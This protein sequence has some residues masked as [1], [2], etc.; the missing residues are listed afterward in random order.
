M[1]TNFTFDPKKHVY[2]LDGK[3]LTG[4]TTILG[5]IAKPALIGWAAKQTAEWI[6]ENCKHEITVPANYPQGS[7]YYVSELDLQEAVK[8]H[9]KKKEAGGQKGTDLHSEVEIYIKKC[10]LEGG[11]SF[12][13]DSDEIA[14]GVKGSRGL[15]IFSKWAT[16]NGIKFLASEKKVYSRDWWVAGTFDFSFEKDGKRYVGDLKTMK[17]VWDRTPFFQTAA[18]MKMSEEMGEEPYA[19]SCI[20]NIAKETNELTEHWTYDIENDKKAFEA[21]LVLYRQLNQ[22]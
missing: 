2:T 3:P 13:I 19:G 10:I 7:S 17:K 4:V 16:D 8:A 22:F 20:V 11:R 18:Y 5:V 1:S 12:L 14:F 21:A 6:R 9:T 15:A